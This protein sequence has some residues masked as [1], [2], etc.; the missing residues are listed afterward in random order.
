MTKAHGG[1]VEYNNQVVIFGGQTNGIIKSLSNSVYIFNV[2]LL[3]EEST[4]SSLNEMIVEL[5]NFNIAR[6][7]FSFSLIKNRLLLYGGISENNNKLESFEI[8]DLRTENSKLF[9]NSPINLNMVDKQDTGIINIKSVLLPI[10]NFKCSA[11]NDKLEFKKDN[12]GWIVLGGYDSVSKALFNFNNDDR[13]V[14]YFS[15]KNIFSR[16]N[17]LESLRSRGLF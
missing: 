5:K 14:D 3:F 8:Y 16:R 2:L 1:M 4:G 15:E 10:K 6:Q 7:Y 13:S 11:N 12:T 17:R 9:S